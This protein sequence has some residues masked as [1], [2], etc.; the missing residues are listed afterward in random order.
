MLSILADRTFDV[1]VMVFD[2]LLHRFATLCNDLLIYILYLLVDLAVPRSLMFTR[3]LY[4]CVCCM[5]KA[6]SRRTVHIQAIKF[7]RFRYNFKI[8][9]ASFVTT[10]ARKREEKE[11]WEMLVKFPAG[12]VSPWSFVSWVT[13]VATCRIFTW[14]ITA[15]YLKRVLIAEVKHEH[16]SRCAAQSVI[17]EV[18]PFQMWADWEVRNC[19]Q[20]GDL[21]FV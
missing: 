11:G 7:L 4:A 21:Q 15:T 20:I 19:R 13:Y 17:T 6:T 16:V 9:I 3:K 1:F 8:K 12:S 10:F 2:H 18:R 5:W 14:K